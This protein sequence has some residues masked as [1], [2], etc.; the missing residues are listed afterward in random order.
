MFLTFAASNDKS[1]M[2]APSTEHLL[3]GQPEFAAC[4]TRKKRLSEIGKSE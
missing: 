3:S 2:C 1:A 4:P